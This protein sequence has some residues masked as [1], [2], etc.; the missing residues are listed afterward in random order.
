MTLHG[1]LR[2]NHADA[3]SVRFFNRRTRSGF[4]DADDVNAHSLANRRQRKR[5]C[6]IAGDNKKL[7]TARF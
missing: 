2:R 3:F 7:D 5:R 4:Y 6:G 1:G